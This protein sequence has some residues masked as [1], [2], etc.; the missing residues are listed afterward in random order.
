M[1]L[2]S[3]FCTIEYWQLSSNYREKIGLAEV[4]EIDLVDYVTTR[5]STSFRLVQYVR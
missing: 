2:D 4:V 1:K 3:D 5:D